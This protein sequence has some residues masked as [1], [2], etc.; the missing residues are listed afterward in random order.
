MYIFIFFIN[1]DCGFT[2]YGSI[3]RCSACSNR[4]YCALCEKEV[5]SSIDRELPNC[6]CP[7]GYYDDISLNDCQGI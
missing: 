7:A 5:S 4:F 1:I 6:N 3:S 2:H